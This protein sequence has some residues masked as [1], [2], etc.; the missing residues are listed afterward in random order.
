MSG[1]HI[2]GHMMSIKCSNRLQ[3]RCRVPVQVKLAAACVA[4]HLLQRRESIG[5]GSLPL[6]DVR[7]TAALVS[8]FSWRSKHLSRP[9]QVSSPFKVT[10]AKERTAKQKLCIFAAFCHSASWDL[11]ESGS[12]HP[13]WELSFLHWF[14]PWHADNA[15]MFHYRCVIHAYTTHTLKPHCVCR[16]WP[17][18][19]AAAAAHSHTGSSHSLPL[20]TCEQLDPGSSHF[21]SSFSFFVRQSF[22]IWN[23]FGESVRCSQSL[24]LCD[25]SS[26][27]KRSD[28]LLCLFLGW[29]TA[30]LRHF[31]RSRTFFG[32]LLC[33]LGSSVVTL[34]TFS[35]WHEQ[36]GGSCSIQSSPF[37]S[38]CSHLARLASFL[39]MKPHFLHKVHWHCVTVM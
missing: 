36:W 29:I 19:A 6:V 21:Q 2:I 13:L 35:C 11:C 4:I 9:V 37:I 24:Q 12:M 1:N 28:S 39:I 20:R 26:G 27:L 8:S 5:T 34:I 3:T 14:P 17:S 10:L 7:G 23:S 32:I 25:F 16:E 22:D 31:D 38:C 15:L 18:H 30:G 33:F